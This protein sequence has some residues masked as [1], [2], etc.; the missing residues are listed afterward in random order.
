MY[1][2]KK[3]NSNAI[4]GMYHQSQRKYIRSN[5]MKYKWQYRCFGLRKSDKKIEEIASH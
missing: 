4:Q 5:V 2:L 1:Y 3:C